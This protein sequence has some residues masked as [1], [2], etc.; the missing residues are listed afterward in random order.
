MRR[1]EVVSL[2]SFTPYRWSIVS[3]LVGCYLKESIHN[4]L[5]CRWGFMLYTC[6]HSLDHVNTPDM[7]TNLKW[8]FFWMTLR[9]TPIPTFKKS[10]YAH[11]G[12][13]G[14]TSETKVRGAT[15]YW[16]LPLR[17]KK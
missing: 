2:M 9:G 16:S 7:T 1:R 11:T 10:S 4:T 17:L 3:T 6:A 15:M 12:S 8:S 13:L 5:M 14:H